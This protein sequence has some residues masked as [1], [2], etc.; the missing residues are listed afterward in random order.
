MVWHSIWPFGHRV[1]P[2]SPNRVVDTAWPTLP[3]CPEAVSTPSRTGISSHLDFPQPIKKRGRTSTISA[4]RTWSSG[5]LVDLKDT[6]TCLIQEY[7][8]VEAAPDAA[9]AD[10]GADIT[11]ARAAAPLFLPPLNIARK[12]TD[13]FGRENWSSLLAASS[14]P[15]HRGGDAPLGA[16]RRS[17]GGTAQ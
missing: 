15:R 5:P 14:E 11:E 6:H 2:I 4:P 13:P 16:P 1:R 9:P 10:A 7:K 8:C 17:Q 12:A 3:S